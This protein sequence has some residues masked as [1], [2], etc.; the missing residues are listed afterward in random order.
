[1]LINTQDPYIFKE[2][3]IN[4]VPVYYNH[5]PWSP[6][7]HIILGFKVGSMH[8]PIKKE[9]LA[10]FLEHCIFNGCPSMPL[11]KDVRE[12]RKKYTID[13]MNGHTSY[14]YTEY[15]AKCLPE[16]FSKTLEGMS[17]MIF[18]SFL[19]EKWVEHERKI[20]TQEIRNYHKN[21]KKEKY[22]KE[23]LKNMRPGLPTNRMWTAAGW[24]ETVAKTTTEDLKK[25]YQSNYHSG[26][27]YVIL[28][29]HVDKN[30]LSEVSK[31]LKQIPKGISSADTLRHKK[32]RRPLVRRKTYQSGAIGMEQ[33]HAT[34]ML[35]TN[36]PRNLKNEAVLNLASSFLHA[37]LFDSLREEMALCYGVHVGMHYDM[38]Y[39]ENY[40]SLNL[41]ETKIKEAEDK[42]FEMIEGIKKGKYKDK[43]EQQKQIKIDSIKAKERTAGYIIDS[44]S[45]FVVFEGKIPSL[46]KIL[47]DREVLTYKEVADYI[48]KTFRRENLYIETILP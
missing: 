38:D 35:E 17:E 43:F 7:T 3:K 21:K 18:Q 41:P 24:T 14:W 9:G 22:L 33:D 47:R 40:I 13:S 6:C 4:G 20:I 26:N 19:E 36:I 27:M 2:K 12:F 34:L 48:V 39:I 29:G 10:H 23:Y 45:S 32:V 16:K 37:I 25:W 8:D 28:A 31:M 44:A 11:P 30:T 42:I 46:K 5:L 15:T 1:M